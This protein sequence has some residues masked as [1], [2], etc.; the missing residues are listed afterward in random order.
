MAET[1]SESMRG[2]AL[3]RH[4]VGFRSFL[5]V[6]PHDGGD[7]VEVDVVRSPD[8]VR[9]SEPG[10]P[11][12]QIYFNQMEDG[13]YLIDPGTHLDGSFLWTGHQLGLRY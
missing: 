3:G 7:H 1:A 8:G 2:I 9:V 5:I 13:T 12:Q 4:R 6:Q 11:G 10:R